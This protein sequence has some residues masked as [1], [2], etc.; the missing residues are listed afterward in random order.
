[1][2]V[3]VRVTRSFTQWREPVD[4]AAPPY[5]QPDLGLLREPWRF[6][7]IPRNVVEKHRALHERLA[8]ASRW[9]G[10][11]PYCQVSGGGSGRRGVGGAGFADRKLVDI[12]GEEDGTRAQLRLLKLG[13]LSPLPE[14]LV[15]RFLADCDEV[16]ILEKN[17]PYLEVHLRALAHARQL[18]A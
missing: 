7:P 13:V 17:E 12:L 15:A 2:P 9:V 6:V 4:I 3:I 11:L 14:E 16:L 18:R 5:R 8:A 10:E 1:M